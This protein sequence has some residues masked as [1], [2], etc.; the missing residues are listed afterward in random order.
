MKE[1]IRHY[2]LPKVMYLVRGKAQ[3]RTQI[4]GLLIHYF[5]QYNE[6]HLFLVS[7]YPSSHPFTSLNHLVFGRFQD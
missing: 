2:N 1:R 4:L 7:L 3:S 6:Q 5:F